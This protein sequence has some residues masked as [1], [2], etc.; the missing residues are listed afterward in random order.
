M[1][2][3]P[4]SVVVL[5]RTALRAYPYDFRRQFGSSM[6]GAFRDGWLEAYRRGRFGAG[7]FLLKTLL[8]LFVTGLLERAVPSRRRNRGS[9][10]S[11]AMDFIQRDL[12]FAIRV[13][14][15]RPAFTLV[16]IFTLALGVGANTAI[17]SVVN[18]VLLTPLPY[19]DADR[20]VTVWRANDANPDARRNMSAPDVGDLEEVQSLESLVAYTDGSFTLTNLGGAEVVEGARTVGS[21]L[22]VFGLAPRMKRL[23]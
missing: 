15:R 10:R 7:R 1:K 2:D 23:G 19:D 14:L 6:E 17:F 8:N 16:G 4:R 5:F 20:L 12:R 22:G 18:G 3:L 13:L 21:L 11:R 9:R